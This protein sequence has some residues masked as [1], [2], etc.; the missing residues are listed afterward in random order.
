MFLSIE[1]SGM[2]VGF[3]GGLL[4]LLD[5]TGQERTNSI[6]QKVRGLFSACLGLT[7]NTFGSTIHFPGALWNEC[8]EELWEAVV[9]AAAFGFMILLFYLLSMIFNESSIFYKLFYGLFLLF[10]IPTVIMLFIPVIALAFFIPSLLFVFLSAG[11][12]IWLGCL[13][14]WVMAAPL[15]L[16]VYLRNRYGFRA[17]VPTAGLILVVVG[18]ALQFAGSFRR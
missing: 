4:T 14:V 2:I 12:L 17:A 15:L 18:F 10:A 8:R 9:P 1:Q 3:L 13:F 11:V 16:G 7:R 5:L 6:E